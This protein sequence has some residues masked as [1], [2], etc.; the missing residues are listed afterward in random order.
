MNVRS[1]LGPLLAQLPATQERVQYVSLERAEALGICSASRL[2]LTL[3]ILLESTL[4]HAEDLS[5]LDLSALTSRPRRA[6]LEFRPARLLLQDFTGVPLMT[7]LASLRDEVAVRGGDPRR[8]NPT[9]PIDFVCDHALIAEY[10]GRPDAMDLN[11]RIEV[12]DVCGW[13]HRAEPQKG[14]NRS[15][16]TSKAHEP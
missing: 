13:R 11:E 10:G 2:P 5:V 12:H 4:R 3:K 15:C 6:N 16:Q 9:I 7:D 1:S 14:G 8:V